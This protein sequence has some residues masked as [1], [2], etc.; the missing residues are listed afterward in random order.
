MSLDETSLKILAGL[1][2]KRAVVKASLTRMRTFISNFDVTE[3]PISLLVF[4]QEELPSINRKFDE[5]QTEI[6]LLDI[7]D[8]SKSDEERETFENE[9]FTV[10]SQIHELINNERLMGEAAS[11][12][13]LGNCQGHR[14]QLAPISLP[15]FDGNIQEWSS[16]Y[17]IY[18][19]MVHED[20]PALDLVRSIPINDS[21]YTVVLERLQHRYDNKSLVIQSHIRSI[22]DCPRIEE[23]SSGALQKLYAHICTHVAALQALDQPVEYWDAWLITIVTG[24]LDKSTGHGW[25]LHL[26]NTSLPKYSDL[27]NFLASRCVALENSE[28]VMNNELTGKICVP[29]NLT[30]K[31]S[32]PNHKLYTKKGLTAYISNDIK[33]N[34]CSGSHKLYACNKFKE[35]PM[36]ERVTVVRDL[37]LCFNCL[38]PHHTAD[39][40]K[41]K[42]N[43]FIC[44]GRHNTLLHYERQNEPT[45]FN[46][47]DKSV[48][49]VTSSPNQGDSKKS[50]LVQQGHGHVFL[51][52]AVVLIRD[53][54]GVFKNCHA[55]LDSGSQVNFISKGLARQL[56]LPATKST[57]P[58]S[59]IGANTLQSSTCVD[60][61]IESRFGSSSFKLSCYTL[62]VI[63]S[64]LQP[65]RTPMEG[66]TIPSELLPQLA[67]P[68]FYDPKQIDLLIG[69]SIFFDI[70]QP[71]RVQLDVNRL[72]LQDS[73]L[74]WIVTGEM[75]NTCLLSINR[76]FEEESKIILGHEDEL[77]DK[78][79]KANQSSIEENH[80]LEHFQSTFKRNEE[81]RFVLQLPVKT[82]LTNLGQSVNLATSRFL[83]VER[84]LQ[85]DANLRI[86]YTK[87]MK[88][89]LD[90]GHMQEVPKE[91]NIPKR[92]CYLPHHAVFKSS[93]LTTKTRIVFDASAK[94]S[95]GLSLNDV[96][97]RGPKTQEDI[98]LILTRFRKYQYV[99]SSDIEKMFRQVA[100]AEQD[101]DLQRILWR[102]DPSEALRT[103]QLVTVT[104]GTKPA[105]FMTT[106]CL[107]T[108]AQQTYEKFPRAAKAIARDFYMDDLMTGGETEAECI[109]LYQQITS[110]LASAKLPLRKWCSNSSHVLEHIGKDVSDPLFTLEL[111][112]EEVIKSLG[113]CWNP[114]LDE[115]RFNVIPTPVRPKLTKRT[116]LSDLNK[117]FDP[118]G[119]IAPILVKGKIFLQQIWALK[120]DW[121]S[122]LSSD[123]QDRWMSFHKDLE[124]LQ[125]VSIPRKVLPNPDEFQIHGFCDASQEAYGACIYVR[126]RSSDNTWQ[127]RL[128]CARSRVAPIKGSTIPR[129]EL[130]GA[131]VLTQLLQ[132]LTESWEIDRY[133]CHLWTDSTVVLSWLNA[134]SN[135]L[136][137]Y[138]SNR[139]NQILELTNTSQWNYV[140]TNKNPADMIS[141]GT[142]VKEI[143]TSRLWWTGPDWLSVS[144]EF[145]E[146][147]PRSILKEEEIPEQRIIRFALVGVQSNKELVQ[148]FS[149]WSR[150]KRATAWLQRFIVYLKTKRVP[151][152]GHLSV[153]ELQL[154][155]ACIL[156]QVQAEC[157]LDELQ[158]LKSE[159]ELR[160]D[161]KLK[162][163]HPFIKDELILVGGRLD[164][165]KLSILQRHPVVLPAN[166]KVT[167]LIFEQKHL[168]QLHCGP[169][170]LLAEVR[171]R[172]WPLRSRVMARSVVSRCVKCIRAKPTFNAPLMAS[173]PKERVQ[174]M[175]P[176]AVTGVDFA[177][178]I[179]IRSGI[180]RVIGVKAWIAVFVCFTTR[181]VHLE[182]V[183]DLSSQAFLASL[184]RFTARRGLCST[185][186]SD[187]ATNFVGAKRELYSHIKSAQPQI[188]QRGIEWRFNPPSAPH[189]G[190]LWESAVKSAKHHLTRIMGDAR[191]SI[192]EL[193]TLLC[194]IEACLNSRPLTPI[195]SDPSDIEALTPAHF[196]IGGPIS[197]PP[198]VDLRRESLSSL[199]RWKY[200][201]YLMQLFW[202]RWSSEYLP[203]LQIR[204]KWTSNKTI[205][206]IGD[207][208]IIRDENAP[209]TKWKLGRVVNVHPGKD[210]V[211]R[212]V[213]MRLGSGAE[214]KR[215]IV[216]LCLLPTEEES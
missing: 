77:Y 10:R 2:R 107:V 61:H 12:A 47:E 208:A 172:Y 189:F 1:K 27:E 194:Q 214:L 202:Q 33:C 210:G 43:C 49:D 4:R 139:V 132:R 54:Q 165:S 58:V 151:S 160:S 154:A 213:T 82:D 149:S 175:R 62:P 163:L 31:F 6:E 96:L 71:S 188:A 9:F 141:R 91:S 46:T 95:S 94:T 102:N 185:I 68:H 193:S 24:R 14:T 187:N 131:L 121:D 144:D 129:L 190:G 41:S 63:M 5:V 83:S 191:L 196:L 155:E 109:Q 53:N 135:R 13:S 116:L 136:K 100:V 88:D 74:G 15:G 198:E 127:V 207:I 134:Q 209:P 140:R 8:I 59:G 90:M 111:G 113:L 108:L 138:V 70:L 128:L 36:G 75:N 159:R 123:I 216:K 125:D 93:S 130:N 168:E 143:S 142:N 16:F 37:K 120:I 86:E 124:Q 72:Y 3:Q 84:K 110:I 67:D 212:V 64:Q 32:K 99:I 76:S 69:G 147:V 80:A 105:S 21:N 145:W 39:K 55:I 211:V 29:N 56:Q 81:G 199:R 166:H 51:S 179:I 73:K 78:K 98:F 215:P 186:F 48:E 167:R 112:D 19:A 28:A 7:E 197:L 203:Q 181:A 170:A 79:S 40:C 206:K 65:V 23:A 30:T 158:N 204:G 133:K 87:F 122:P 126:S 195:S 20:S 17:D 42:F 57:L 115:F 200:V 52:T 119:F 174:I 104:Y 156:K 169:Q 162:S 50:L 38:H 157:F 89:Y 192:G 176:F 177:G 173:L 101:W 152:K 183:E 11:N 118:I 171:R 150:L 180:R 114:V 205:L 103:Y 22:L 184:R 137:V 34:W 164:N 66:W 106:Q 44:K 18:R 92:S 117:V 35:L 146:Q 182:S 45:I 25:Q 178:P 26:K 60:I 153:K 97:M 201:Q 148:H 161:S 85:Q